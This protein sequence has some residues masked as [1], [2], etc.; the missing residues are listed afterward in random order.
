MF[1][2]LPIREVKLKFKIMCNY[3]QKQNRLECVWS[4]MLAGTVNCE[5]RYA[6]GV[7]PNQVDFI[8]D[9]GTVGG[10]MGEREMNI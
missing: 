8:N 5:P 9:S 10:V 3:H 7:R 6:A 1:L 2:I 4:K